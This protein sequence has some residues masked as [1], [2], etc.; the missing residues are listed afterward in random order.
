MDGTSL[1]QRGARDF[2]DLLRTVN[3]QPVVEGQISASE[4][5][6]SA[7]EAPLTLAGVEVLR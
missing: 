7:F 5:W 2:Q 1:S 6:L 3:P 4:R